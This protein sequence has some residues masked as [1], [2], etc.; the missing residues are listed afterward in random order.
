MEQAL[1]QLAAMRPAVRD[2][3][4]RMVTRACEEQRTWQSSSRWNR[5]QPGS[6]TSASGSA[7]ESLAHEAGAFLVSFRGWFLTAAMRRALE[8][9]GR[10]IVARSESL[11]S[12]IDGV[13]TNDR[14]RRRYS[15]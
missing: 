6:P 1:A 7:D 5:R 3:N 12:R 14:H 11:T 15:W 4:G 8:S 9:K 10:Q 13:L 2:A